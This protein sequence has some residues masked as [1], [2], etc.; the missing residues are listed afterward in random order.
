MIMNSSITPRDQ[1]VSLAQ[2][3][4]SRAVAITLTVLSLFVARGTR[5]QE[6]STLPAYSPSTQVYGVIRSCGNPAMADLLRRWE[7][8][9]HRYQPNVQFTE[10]LVSSASAIAGLSSSTGD[11]ALMGRQIFT[12]EYYGIYR[13]SLM[14]PIEIEVATGSLNV[15]TKSFALAVLV[16]KDNPLSQLSLEQLD[17]IFGAEREGGWQ[18]MVWNKNVAHTAKDNLGTWGQL[19]LTGE[20]ADKPIHLYGPPGLYPGGYSFFQRKVMGGADTFAEGLM[21]FNDRKEMIA[22]LGADPYGIAYTGLC[23]S[24]NQTKVIA[25]AQNGSGPFVEP[26]RLTVANRTYPLSRPVYIYFAP[27]TP[28]G[29]VASPKE[30]AK[31]REFLKYVVSRQGQEDVVSE[32]DYL[33]LTT[34][35]A[36]EQLVKLR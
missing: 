30:T 6:I 13:R 26:T 35:V 28:G 19:G 23:Y 34:A 29:E 21:E 36:T 14:L 31:V 27:D 5:A 10:N 32:G 18:G 16:N 2:G 4:V 3:N 11:L 33:P 8:G 24:T 22:K 1:A 20:W 25:L 12:Y 15:P 17:H 9:F 7:F